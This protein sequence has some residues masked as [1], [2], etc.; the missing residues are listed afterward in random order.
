[1]YEYQHMAI[2]NAVK[3]VDININKDLIEENQSDPT[4]G[5]SIQV[6]FCVTTDSLA[7]LTVHGDGRVTAA[8]GGTG[9]TDNQLE[10]YISQGINIYQS[11]T[12]DTDTTFNH[13]ALNN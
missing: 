5:I 1:M 7:W 9:T 4:A 2:K 10:E 8:F 6:T 12:G 11:I 3:D 13:P